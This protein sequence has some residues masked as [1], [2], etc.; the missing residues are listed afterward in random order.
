MIRRPPRSTLFPYT[1]L[2]RSL[3]KLL[4]EDRCFFCKALFVF[5]GP[6]FREVSLFVK[7]TS[8]VVKSMGKLVPDDGADCTVVHR[9][10]RPGIKKRRLEN[11]GGKSNL[12]PLVV[13][14]GVY[15]LRQH[16][17]LCLIHFFVY[18][19]KLPLKCHGAP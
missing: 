16:M 13:V 1:T 6:P 10:I 3:A 11:G 2:F 7:L 19:S 12:I 8:L 17:P 14:H 9:I 18:F 5:F 4:H 15:R